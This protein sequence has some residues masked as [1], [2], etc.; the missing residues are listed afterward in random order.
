[1]A[2]VLYGIRP[3]DAPTFVGM[4]LLLVGVAVFACYV[5]A[6][7]ALRVNPIVALRLE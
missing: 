3:A 5:P 1:M 7:R 2:R 4:T 6:R